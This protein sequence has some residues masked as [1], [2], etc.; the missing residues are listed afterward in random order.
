MSTYICPRCDGEDGYQ[1]REQ[2]LQNTPVGGNPNYWANQLL[3]KTEAVYVDVWKCK[4]CGEYM[5]THYQREQIKERAQALEAVMK[6]HSINNEKRES[7]LAE[8]EQQ[9]KDNKQ[10]YENL[11]A[12]LEQQ[13]KDKKQKYEDEK[14]ERKQK[15]KDEL[16]E[17]EQ[18][19]KNRLE[20]IEQKKKNRKKDL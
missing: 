12:E 16:A 20:E 18:K 2:R 13:K 6:E 10:K 15:F 9:K 5:I 8:L 4:A 11:K 1:T 14:A 7:F 19:K 3:K 17:I